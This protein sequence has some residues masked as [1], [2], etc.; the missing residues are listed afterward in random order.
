VLSG[1]HNNANAYQVVD[2]LSREGFQIGNNL[3]SY[4]HLHM[5]SQP[6]MIHRFIAICQQFGQGVSEAELKK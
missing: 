2:Y 5:A 4:I 1:E 6:S 3:A